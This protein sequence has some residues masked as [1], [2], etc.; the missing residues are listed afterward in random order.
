MTD[1]KK[2]VK[3][4]PNTR[5]QRVIID[6]SDGYEKDATLIEQLCGFV[7]WG[8][9]SD[10]SQGVEKIYTRIRADHRAF[11]KRAIEIKNFEGDYIPWGYRDPTRHPVIEHPD[12]PVIK[13]ADIL[14]PHRSILLRMEGLKQ[15]K[16]L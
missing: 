2:L 9:T 7:P 16:Q 14:N 1:Y 13:V 15:W 6:L 12:I 5:N 11:Y 3:A 4:V 10:R 8:V